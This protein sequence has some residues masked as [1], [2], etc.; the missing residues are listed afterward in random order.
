LK[1]SEAFP[2]YC[3][4]RIRY[5]CSYL[6]TV[7]VYY[8]V[9]KLKSAHGIVEL[10]SST[11][12]RMVSLSDL[13]IQTILFFSEKQYSLKLVRPLMRD[14]VEVVEALSGYP[15]HCNHNALKCRKTG[16]VIDFS[17]GQYIG[18]M[19]PIVFDNEDAFAAA[20]P[21]EVG[22]IFPCPQKDIDEQI[23][24]D[25]A[26]FKSRASPDSLSSAFTKRVLRSWGESKQFCGHCLGTASAGS[27]MKRCSRCRTAAYC[28]KV[29]QTIHW[30]KGHKLECGSNDE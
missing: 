13:E 25:N 10:W 26:A 7:F 18:S 1:T 5:S 15:P 21:G 3:R 8:V 12:K 22:R 28:G 30:K 11:L 19:S 4:S 16:A 2:W 9:P 17:L 27:A 20:I 6:T 14:Q 24:R 23:K 29:C